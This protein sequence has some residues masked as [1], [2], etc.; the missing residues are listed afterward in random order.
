LLGRYVTAGK[1]VGVV[2]T[3]PSIVR[4]E[5]GTTTVHDDGRIHF[6]DQDKVS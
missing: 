5:H 6:F 4:F 2:K 1:D 3:R